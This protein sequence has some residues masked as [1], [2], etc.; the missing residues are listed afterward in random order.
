MNI[1]GVSSF[2]CTHYRFSI[3]ADYITRFETDILFYALLIIFLKNSGVH[4]GE[5]PVECIMRGNS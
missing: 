5:S 3:S 4:D 1:A 2:S